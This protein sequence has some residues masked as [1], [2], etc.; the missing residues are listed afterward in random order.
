MSYYFPFSLSLPLPPPTLCVGDRHRCHNVPMQAP[1]QPAKGSS[2]LSPY[3]T[4]GSNSLGSAAESLPAEP[5]HWPL[6]RHFEDYFTSCSLS[7]LPGARRFHTIPKASVSGC[8]HEKTLDF[9]GHWPSISLFISAWLLKEEFGPTVRTGNF[10]FL[11]RKPILNEPCSEII[12]DTLSS[13]A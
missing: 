9:F 6:L 4:W 3:G 13:L 2:F 11:C 5:S 8:N 7:S 1:G 12:W 10:A